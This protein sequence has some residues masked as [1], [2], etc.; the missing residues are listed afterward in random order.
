[1]ACDIEIN[2]IVLEF[3]CIPDADRL[4][5]LYRTVQAEGNFELVIGDTDD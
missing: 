4:M 3:L 2:R 5:D 1:M